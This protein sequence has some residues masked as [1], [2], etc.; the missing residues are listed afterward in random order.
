ML[1]MSLGLMTCFFY[2][3]NHARNT[4]SLFITNHLIVLLWYIVDDE[5]ILSLA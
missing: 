2:N 3:D 4:I 1:C 5:K